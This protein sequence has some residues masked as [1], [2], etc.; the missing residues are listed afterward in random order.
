MK[1]EITKIKTYWDKNPNSRAIIYFTYKD[2]GVC[3]MHINEGDNYATIYGLYVDEKTSQ[4][5]Y[6]FYASKKLRRRT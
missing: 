4:W 2:I 3:R 6:W 5:R 1:N